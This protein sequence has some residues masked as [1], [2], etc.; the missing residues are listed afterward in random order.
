MKADRCLYALFAERNGVTTLIGLAGIHVDDFLLSGDGSP[1]FLEAESKLQ[2]AFRWGKWDQDEFDFAGTHIVQHSDKSITMN[3]KD[4][5]E[6]WIEEVSIDPNRSRKS[7]LTP[8][9]VTAL[10]GVL[11]TISWRSTQTAPEYLAETS[12]LLS[13]IGKATIET[14]HKANKLVREMRRRAAQGLLFPTWDTKDFAVVT[15]TDAS[16]GNRPDRSSTVG[17]LSALA[18]ADVLW[19]EERQFS[20]L[21][22]KSGK[23]PRQSW[24]K[25]IGSPR[26]YP[27][28]RHEL[29][30]SRPDR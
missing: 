6:R 15:W 1:E 30:T 18:P 7:P 22:W 5:T 28:R 14:L 20:V 27:W 13:E 17:I 11:G 26:T 4:Y 10:R 23:A 24:I 25:R 16:Q 29:P 2:S 21:Q 3:Q 9:E 12:L 19:G 8:S